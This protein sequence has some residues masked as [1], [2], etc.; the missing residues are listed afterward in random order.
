MTKILVIE[1][2][3]LVRE[4]LL[5]LLEAEDFQAIGAANGRLGVKLAQEMLPDL[6]ICDVMMPELD[7]YGVLKTLQQNVATATIPF[8]FVTAKSDENDLRQGMALGSDDYLTKPYHPRELLQAIMVRLQ[9]QARLQQKTQQQ[10]DS[11]RTSITLS[12]PSELRIPLDTILDLSETLFSDPYLVTP[13]EIATIATHIHTCANQ[14]H[15]LIQDFLD[16]AQLE[17]QMASK[18]PQNVEPNQGS[19]QSR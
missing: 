1:D 4:N 19:H 10:L 13:E 5:D 8:I 15:H 7:G 18:S 3:T 16:R 11:L 14:V 9:K 12:M 2:E 6:I 17:L